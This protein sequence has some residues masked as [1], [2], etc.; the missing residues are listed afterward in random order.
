MIALTPIPTI[1]Q[2]FK[3][4][5]GNGY[6]SQ[7]DNPYESLA[8]SSW[9]MY[10]APY[11]HY[12]MPHSG[13]LLDLFRF[14]AGSTSCWLILRPSRIRRQSL[15]GSQFLR[16]DRE[17]LRLALQNEADHIDGTLQIE[18]ARAQDKII[19]LRIARMT[20]IKCL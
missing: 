8:F 7:V 19:K 17:P 16:R 13:S 12:R 1:G 5:V 3:S 6:C 14:R 15:R 18:D 10:V 20:V 2:A 9:I 11:L 4:Q